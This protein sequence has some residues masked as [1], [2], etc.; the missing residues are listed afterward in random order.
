MFLELRTSLC[1][2]GDGD[3]WR[4]SREWVGS[5]TQS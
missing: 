4:F 1:V 3:M 2:G 5:Q